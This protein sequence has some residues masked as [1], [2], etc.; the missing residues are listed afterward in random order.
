MWYHVLAEME[1][2]WN[3]TPA[4][5]WVCPAVPRPQ[6]RASPPGVTPQ[7]WYLPAETEANV[8]PAGTSV[9]PILWGAPKLGQKFIPQHLASPSGVKPQVCWLP[10][11]MASNVMPAGTEACP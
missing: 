3:V 2:A 10:A 7:V 5:T 11:E 9:D 1:T 6:H 4:G 8:T